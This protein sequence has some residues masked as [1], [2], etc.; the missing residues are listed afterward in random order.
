MRIFSLVLLFV[1][2]ACQAPEL[3]MN[4]YEMAQ[5]DCEQLYGFRR[6]T[7]AYGNCVQ[8]EVQ[9]KKDIILRGYFGR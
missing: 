3:Q 5:A 6:G 1:L 4:I 7:D 8:R 2:S 9:S